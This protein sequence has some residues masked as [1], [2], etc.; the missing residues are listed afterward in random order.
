M[1]PVK[2]LPECGRLGV[3]GP[4]QPRDRIEQDHDVLA[5]FDHSL[6]LFDDHLGDLDMPRGWLVEGGADHLGRR[7]LDRALHV[8]DFL[9]ALVDQEHHDIRFGVVGQDAVGDLL[10]ED[11]LAGSGRRDDHAALAE[12]ERS[13]QVDDPH[14]GLFGVVSSRIRPCGCSGVRSSKPT[15]SLSLSGSSKLIASTRK[16]SEVAFVFLGGPDLA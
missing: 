6:G 4:R 13:D 1:P 3:V 15:F 16:Q 9:G 8:G 2:I 11:G 12:A 10:E 7:P 5:E 14:V